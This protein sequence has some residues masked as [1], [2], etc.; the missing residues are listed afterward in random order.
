MNFSNI[1]YETYTQIIT[2]TVI[3]KI[4]FDIRSS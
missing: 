2:Q 3:L 4:T 1:Y